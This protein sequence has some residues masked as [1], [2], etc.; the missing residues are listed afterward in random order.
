MI[1]INEDECQGCGVCVESCPRGAIA[2]VDGYAHLDRNQCNDCG[3]CVAACPSGAITRT[4][5]VVAPAREIVIARAAPPVQPGRLA[6]AGATLA[7]VGAQ[8]LP[9]FLDLLGDYLAHRARAR[10]PAMLSA[11]PRSGVHRRQRLRQGRR[12][13]RT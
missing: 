12:N 7:A 8:I 5:P 3:E 10:Q 4:E 13:R 9:Y 11:R 1:T 6:A 2:L